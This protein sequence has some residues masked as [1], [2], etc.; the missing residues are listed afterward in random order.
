MSAFARS[1]AQAFL[2]AAPSPYDVQGFLD[3]AD[4]IARA[5]AADSRLRAFFGAPAVAGEAK[6]G[7]LEQLALRVGLDP[8]GRRL[9]QLILKN[10]RLL[11]LPA[12][13]SA[14]RAEADRASGVVQARVTVAAAIGE[15]ERQRIAQA[16]ERAVGK[17][18]RLETS[19]D[20]AI[21]GGFVA[22]VGSEVFDASILRAIEQFQR[23]ASEGT[24]V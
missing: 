18:V 9:L 5:L 12:I 17:P 23:Q 1:Y 4:T 8:Y 15:V 7:A 2:Q 20:A 3:R 21:L 10:R 16:L 14:L 6:S 11:N 22:R 13:L 19:V 24:G